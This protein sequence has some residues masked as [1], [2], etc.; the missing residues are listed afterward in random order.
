[1]NTIT[2][3]GVGSYTVMIPGLQKESQTQLTT[4]SE[5][6]E[7]CKLAST[8]SVTGTTATEHV[9]NCYAIGGD[10]V[11]IGFSLLQF[12][13]SLVTPSAYLWANEP[14]A[15]SY[16]P[17]E[18]YQF[19]SAG[20]TNTITRTDAGTYTVDLPEQGEESGNIQV[21]AMNSDPGISCEVGRWQVDDENLKQVEVNCFD[22]TGTRVDA[23]FG[24]LYVDAN[25]TATAGVTT[26][27]AFLIA[28]HS[29]EQNRYTPGQN[30]QY[31]SAGTPGD[32]QRTGMGTYTI[33]LPE[34]GV[35]TGIIQ[36]TASGTGKSV[37]CSVPRWVLN[38]T[39]YDVD[40]VCF[41]IEGNPVDSFFNLTYVI[42][43]SAGEAEGAT[44]P[45]ATPVS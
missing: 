19:N 42:A 9:V 14:A 10:P 40:V 33:S 22:S 30:F 24:L 13:G 11:D 12:S 16:T 4:I 1:M 38:D 34:V 20:E 26:S 41:D 45:A 21:T 29:S 37:T 3:T 44:P 31:S 6:G 5:H 43:A 28:D 2:R 36:V 17:D 25:D 8:K 35:E 27:G 39:T 32:S 15:E 18:R 23:K 7:R